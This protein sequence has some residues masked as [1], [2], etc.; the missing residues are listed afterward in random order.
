MTWMMSGPKPLYLN[1]SMVELLRSI[2]NGHHL[3]QTGL[4]QIPDLL[5]IKAMGLA[6]SDFE[7]FRLTPFGMEV[8]LANG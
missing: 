7:G 3:D 8:F 6:V 4:D 5:L 2:A 1:T